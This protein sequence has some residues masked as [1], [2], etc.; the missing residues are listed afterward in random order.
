MTTVLNINYKLLFNREFYID[1]KIKD[2]E[3]I[4]LIP[5]FEYISHNKIELFDFSKIN[6]SDIDITNFKDIE[7]FIL[8]HI[9]YLTQKTI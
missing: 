4:N 6:E 5:V 7:R 8:S 3:T 9:Y 2:A 1:T